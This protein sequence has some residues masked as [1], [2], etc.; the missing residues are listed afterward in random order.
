MLEI[1]L[2]KDIE[3]RLA[4]IADATGRSLAA[5]AAEAIE[6]YVE[7]PSPQRITYGER[8]IVH[9]LAD[10]VDTLA[11]E[12]AAQLTRRYSGTA[13]DACAPCTNGSSIAS[14]AD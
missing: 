7:S 9:M 14:A 12:K 10:W 6:R 2:S 4:K 5:C 1:E 13:I 11:G 3:A 8:I